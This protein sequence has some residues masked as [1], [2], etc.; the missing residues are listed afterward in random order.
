MTDF[1]NGNIVLI[2]MPAS[3]K[4]TVGVI[5]AKILGMDFVDTDIIIQQK[6]GAR[7]NQIIEKDGVEEFLIKEERAILNLQTRNTVVATGGSAVYSSSAME[8][9]AAGSKIVY[10]KVQKEELYSRLKDIQERGVVLRCGETVDEMYDIRAKLYEKYAD[11]TIYEEGLTIEDTV[12]AIIRN[13][14]DKS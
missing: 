10:L 2:G 1:S 14:G 11:I 4:S 13:I 7:L 9:L 8:H 5:L 3:G 12:Q 6:E